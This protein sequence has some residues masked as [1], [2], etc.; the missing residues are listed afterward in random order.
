MRD[1]DGVDR[2]GVD[3][4]GG[5]VGEEVS[6]RTLRLFAVALA[7]A[8][9]DHHKVLA[10]IHHDRRIGVVEHL[11]VEEIRLQRCLHIFGLHIGDEGRRQ[12]QTDNAVGD[13]RHFE[14]AQLVAIE[15]RRLLADLRR[16]SACRCNKRQFTQGR[17]NRYR[18][19]TCE[20]ISAG[21]LFHRNS[22][23]WASPNRS[24]E[25]DR[26][27]DHTPVWPVNASNVAKRQSF[28]RWCLIV[29]QHRG[30]RNIP[31]CGARVTWKI[32]REYASGTMSHFCKADRLAVARSAQDW[33]PKSSAKDKTNPGGNI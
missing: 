1:D 3:A 20:H 7:E 9:I 30:C 4:G 8:G 24:H 33:M 22:L 19:C 26:C 5:K 11:G 13:H 21:Q 29:A 28:R 31:F 6:G 17:G 14:I 32:I 15:A 18:C 16:S 2:V 27:F 25:P 23:Q 12:L 10:G